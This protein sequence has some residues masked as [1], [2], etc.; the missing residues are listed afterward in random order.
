MTN[1]ESFPLLQLHLLKEEFFDAEQPWVVWCGPF[2]LT[3]F[4]TKKEATDW[5]KGALKY[6]R[7]EINSVRSLDDINESYAACASVK[8]ALLGYKMEVVEDA[9]QSA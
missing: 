9:K 3:R 1:N 5:I 4:A 2:P 6:F 7:M 8:Q